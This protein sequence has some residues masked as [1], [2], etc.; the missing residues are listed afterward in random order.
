LETSEAAADDD[1]SMRFL[2][3]GHGCH[4]ATGVATCALARPPVCLPEGALD[5]IIVPIFVTGV[6]SRPYTIQATAR[7]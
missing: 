5:F 6:G 7:R 1:Y 4:S 2:C 3:C